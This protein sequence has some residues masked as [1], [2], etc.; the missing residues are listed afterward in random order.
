VVSAAVAHHRLTPDDVIAMAHAGIL[1]EDARLELVDGVLVEMN[2]LGPSHEDAKE[3][4]VRY[5]DRDAGLAVRVESMFVTEDGY[6]LPDLQVAEAFTRR[7]LSRFAPLVVE[8]AQSS[9]RRDREKIAT[10]A[11]A[12]VPEY[13]I[14]DVLAQLV[15]VHREPAGEAYG[16]VTEHHDGVLHPLLAAPPLELDALFDRS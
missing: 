5:F 9:H 6:V 4:L 13:W 12:G 16:S 11:R 3:W 10:Y 15:V 8:I 7:E 2:P 14:V 1:H